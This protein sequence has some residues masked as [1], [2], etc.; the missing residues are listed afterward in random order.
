MGH[1]DHVWEGTQRE[2]YRRR[3]PR[4]REPQKSTEIILRDIRTG[5]R[6]CPL[7]EALRLPIQVFLIDKFGNR[8]DDEKKSFYVDGTPHLPFQPA[9]LAVPPMRPISTFEHLQT[10][11]AVCQARPSMLLK[12]STRVSK[13][14]AV[15]TQTRTC[16][17]ASTKRRAFFSQAFG[18][19]RAFLR[20][21]R[22]TVFTSR[23]CSPIEQTVRALDALRKEGK[24]KYIGLSE[25]RL[26]RASTALFEPHLTDSPL[27]P[28]VLGGNSSP[29]RERSQG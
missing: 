6:E 19:M 29:C 24:T 3:A 5:C 27:D 28:T 9:W 16:C 13:T 20:L 18:R 7:T 15:S 4:G 11:D 26:S 23:R 12:R 25:V 17:T 8:W 22:E 2:D 21:F 1:G 14:S 10:D